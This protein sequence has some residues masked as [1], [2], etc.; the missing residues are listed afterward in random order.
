M[1]KKGFTL[2][3][4][5]FLV[6]VAGVLLFIAV[7]SFDK[8]IQQNEYKR[9]F[10]LLTEVGI[11]TM[12]YREDSVSSSVTSGVAFSN[13][14]TYPTICTLS[15][16]SFPQVLLSC[17]YIQQEDWDSDYFEI[18]PCL[19]ADGG[20]C[21]N[22]YAYLLRKS[23]APENLCPLVIFTEDLETYYPASSNCEPGF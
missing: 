20:H 14:M 1:C 8:T 12:H 15:G 23:G 2:V 11:G 16:I 4:V 6:I 9:M 21:T 10:G 19:P 17:G 3:E 18:F 13:S 5:L 7:P 22:S